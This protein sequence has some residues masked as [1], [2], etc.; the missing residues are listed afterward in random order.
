M[1]YV[2]VIFGLVVVV[3]GLA[4][5]KFK[6]ISSLIQMGTAMAELYGCP[7]MPSALDASLVT[8]L[9]AWGYEDGLRFAT[10]E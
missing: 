5:V 4:G 9:V 7:D 8:G 1:R 3:G 6:Q 10:C 2:L